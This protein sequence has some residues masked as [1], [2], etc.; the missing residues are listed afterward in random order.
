MSFLNLGVAPFLLGLAAIAILLFLLQRLRVK[1]RE[2]EVVTTL[3]WKQAVQETHT[4]VLMNRFRQFLAYLLALAIAGV[5][6][7]AFA[8]PTLNQDDMVDTIF[9]LDGSAGMAWGDRFEQAKSLLRKE[10]DRIPAARRRIYFCGAD[11]RLV[12]DRGEEIYLL[13]PRLADLAPEACPSSIERDLFALVT[14]ETTRKDLKLFVV[15]DA[16]IGKTW[17][18]KFRNH[19]VIE[20][21]Q[22][23]KPP[24][25]ENNIG[26]SAIGVTNSSSGVFD[27]VDVI[28][29]I[30]GAID[31]GITVTLGDQPYNQSPTNEGGTYYLRDLP[32]RGEVLE[33]A[34]VEE[35]ALALDNRARITLPARH[36]VAVEVDENLDD[37]FHTLIE[38][39]P[40]L[41]R[42]SGKAQII[43]GGATDG[44]LPAIELVAGNDIT[45]IY[46]DNLSPLALEQLQDRFSQTGFDRVGWT[47]SA[48]PDRV[49]DCLLSPHYVPGSKRKVQIGIE[50][51][52]SD[53]DFL[54]SSAFPLFLSSAIRWL[55][56]VEPIEPFVV[57]GEQSAHVG[58]FTLVGSDYAPPRAGPHLDQNGKAFEVSLKAVQRLEN[59][60][61][62]QVTRSTANK[63]WP[64][65]GTGC[66][67]LALILIGAEWWLYQKG[68]IP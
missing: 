24:K 57:A 6:W 41:T 40:A 43:V 18:A 60:A 56:R 12:L 53:Y 19:A 4:R 31:A 8:E 25:L 64:Y 67:L 20:R 47:S 51:I 46:E 14:D 45:V 44:S 37:R 38:A 66:L 39:D 34:L 55:A 30:A 15:G 50:L 62:N 61:I 17:L 27:R 10:A 9:L 23:E 32:A 29:E 11:T 1:F 3:F 5:V 54:Q 33:I 48:D 2:K 59:Q 22:P 28:F 13:M 42:A 52:G 7:L 63:R 65:I 36:T 58:R 49:G 26:I 16:P 35:D 21:L 68:K